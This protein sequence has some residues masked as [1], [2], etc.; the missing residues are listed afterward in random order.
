MKRI[1]GAVIW[2][3]FTL[4]GCGVESIFGTTDQKATW[5]AIFVAMVVAA[6]GLRDR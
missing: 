1:W 5:I 3:C 6:F 2:I 4:C